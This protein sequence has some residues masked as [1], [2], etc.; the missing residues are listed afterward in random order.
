MRLL[1]TLFN[2]SYAKKHV[3]L[4][5]YERGLRRSREP[6][7]VVVGGEGDVLF[8]GTLCGTI[9]LIHGEIVGDGLGIGKLDA[10]TS[11][12]DATI[13]GFVGWNTI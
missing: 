12:I 4:D 13:P 10:F 11:G 5:V 7:D 8:G 1:W 6:R 3:Y 9:R 2:S